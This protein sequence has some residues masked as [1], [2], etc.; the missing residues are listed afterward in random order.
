MATSRMSSFRPKLIHIVS[1]AVL[2]V[3]TACGEH[4]ST[5]KP[6]ASSMESKVRTQVKPCSYVAGHA[7]EADAEL[8]AAAAN[9]DVGRVR[10]VLDSGR[11]VGAV[12]SL[13]RT[14][15]FAAAF[16]NR[17]EVVNL[18]MEKGGSVD[19]RDFLG[20]SPLHAAVLVGGADAAKALLEKGANINGKN[21]AGFT[22]LRL[23]A[24]T[25][26]LAVVEL[27]LERGADVQ[28]HDLDAIDIAPF[29]TKNEHP[30]IVAAV[31]KLRAK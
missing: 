31:K 20:M 8:F 22:P 3:L 25:H 27:L 14:P 28:P 18:L 5:E 23:A 19:A 24:S 11:S 15:L 21:T 13:K 10:S 16:C 26:Q 12:D 29:A 6:S 4:G 17:P 2:G 7:G 1:V 30:I 9:G